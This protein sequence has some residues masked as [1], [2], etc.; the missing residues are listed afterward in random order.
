MKRNFGILPSLIVYPK[1]NHISFVKV[2]TTNYNIHSGF[3]L[4][5]LYILLVLP[6]S[7]SK[8]P[9][10]GH[11]TNSEIYYILVK[12]RFY[13]YSYYYH[14]IYLFIDFWG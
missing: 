12:S 2:R 10:S 14:N 1:I 5:I 13:Q 11:F 7:I 4:I 6:K 9:I 8:Y 3:D